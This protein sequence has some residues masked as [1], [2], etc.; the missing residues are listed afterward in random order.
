MTNAQPMHILYVSQYFPPEVGA[1]SA[2][3][4]ELAKHWVRAGHRVTALTGFPSYPTGWNGNGNGA[5]PPPELT[6]FSEYGDRLRVVRSWAMG[7][8][9]RTPRERLMAWSS[10]SL[11]S[12]LRGIAIPKPDVVLASSPPLT[13]GMTGWWL[14]RLKRKPFVFDVRDLWPES[15]RDLAG[16]KPGAV[17]DR[18]LDAMAGFLY[19][20][21]DRIVVTSEATRQAL[22]ERGKTAPEITFTIPNGVETDMFAPQPLT[23]PNREK[24]KQS[25]GLGGKFIVSFIGT[26][27][28]AQDLDLIIRA[29]EH[30]SAAPP[31]ARPPRIA[32]PANPYTPPAQPPTAKP[33]HNLP[34]RDSPPPSTAE[35]APNIPHPDPSQPPAAKRAPNLPYPDPSQPPTAEP[36]PNLPYP[37]SSQP[38]TM[39]RAPNTPHP[40][41]SQPTTVE[42]APNIPALDP[43][44][45]PT[46][47]P[48]LNLPY[49][50]PSQPPTP[51]PAPNIPTLDPSQP[52]TTEH[53]PN[54]PYPDPSQ[55]PTVER[56]PNLPF[57]DS[58]HPPTA[59]HVPLDLPFRDTVSPPTGKYAPTDIS[60][61]D[62]P[63]P[64]TGKYVPPNI[65][66]SDS[67][68]PPT[69]KYAPLEIPL[70][71]PSPPPTAEPA[72]LY[73]PF[74]PPPALPTED[75]PPG[76][77][78]FLFVGEGPTRQRVV[79]AVRERGLQNF[80]F[81]PAQPR[82]RIPAFIQASD[83]CLVTL[84]QAPVND[85]IIPFRMLEFMACARPVLLSAA[86]ESAR[87]LK[88]ANAGLVIPQGNPEA[89]ANAI[90]HL[91]Q[92]PA[93][94]HQ[95]GQNGSRYITQNFSRQQM[96]QTYLEVLKQAI[97]TP[98]PTP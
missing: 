59:E 4:F 74:R 63:P 26:I 66:Y 94:R 6:A 34:F 62:S 92:N 45:P 42:R 38:P 13:V 88:D 48:A 61:S 2:R 95:A 43:S 75:C 44:Q 64:P 60:Y 51:E 7:V 97:K 80:T 49:P 29:A 72:A 9:S 24:F 35:H 56:A 23:S 32:E 8:G 5:H 58:P 36:A 54:L 65:S 47:E 70:G 89:L 17:A 67:P 96:A 41:P 50:D 33:A 20:S 69:G 3:A 79:E 68:P 77:I 11:S 30:L 91:R 76:D 31:N 39:E 25:L 15:V 81:M 85:V 19:R 83:I 55:P 46:T 10:F 12:S 82:E 18:T 86:G 53:A 22:L 73:L 90:L 37:D 40:N 16:A 71:D 1:G 21:A 78:H 84:R 98:T 14:S 87:I 52:P 57:R 27:G 28:L 93:Q